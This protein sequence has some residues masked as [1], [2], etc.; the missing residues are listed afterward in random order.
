M[1]AHRA[2][3]R[4]A[5]F[6]FAQV[7]TAPHLTQCGDCRTQIANVQHGDS[8]ARIAWYHMQRQTCNRAY[9]ASAISASTI[10]QRRAHDAEI[11]TAADNCLFAFELGREQAATSACAQS[12]R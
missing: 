10:E 8:A 6:H 1:L 4:A 5:Q 7:S 11:D 2:Q 9:P 3:G 12:E